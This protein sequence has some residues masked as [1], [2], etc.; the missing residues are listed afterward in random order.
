MHR[1]LPLLAALGAALTVTGALAQLPKF[2]TAPGKWSYTTRTEIP[3]MGSIP[4]SFE[5]CVTQKDIDEGRNLNSQKD[6]G[7]SCTY[8]DVKVSGTRYQFTAVCSGRDLP[9]PMVTTYDM[10]ATPNQFDAK[11]TATGGH[12]KAMGGK[13]NMS[14]SA[15]RVG[16]C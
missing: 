11:M 9:E 1:P 14:M 10:T 4:M 7:M 8:R 3:G 2:D 12:T 15:K 5:H 6:S 16:G 13:M